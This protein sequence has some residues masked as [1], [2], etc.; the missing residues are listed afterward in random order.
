MKTLAVG[1]LV[2][3]IGLTEDGASTGRVIGEERGRWLTR[4]VIEWT[5]G[6]TSREYMEA[7]NLLRITQMVG[8]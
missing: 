3:W 4:Y 6:V 8:L 7:G 2:M 1:D 5:D